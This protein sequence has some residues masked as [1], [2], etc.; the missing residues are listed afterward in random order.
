MAAVIT[1]DIVNSMSLPAQGMKKLISQLD[2]IFSGFPHE[3]FRGD[4][5]QAYLEDAGLA[6]SLAMQCRA[7]AIRMRQEESEVKVD[8]R[9]AIGLGTVENP[10]EELATARGEAFL[11]SGRALDGLTNTG[12]QIVF[13]IE[14]KLSSLALGVMADYI[15]SIFTQMTSRQAEVI[16]ELLSGMNQQ[17]VAEKLK[18]SKSTISQHVAAGRWD[19]LEKTIRNFKEMVQLISI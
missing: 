18:K 14:N 12:G 4:S 7:C 15:N 11:L 19:E 16:F 1:G 6:L 13:A 8:V 3:F 9:L 2:Q 17:E 10:I 5:F